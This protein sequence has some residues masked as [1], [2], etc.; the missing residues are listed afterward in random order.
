MGACDLLLHANVLKVR[1]I[2]F[3]YYKQQHKWEI[4]VVAF[5]LRTAKCWWILESLFAHTSITAEACHPLS[6]RDR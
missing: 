4:F 6:W 2:P 1:L 5:D 3:L